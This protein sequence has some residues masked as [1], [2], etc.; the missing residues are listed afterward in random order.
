ME[1]RRRNWVVYSV[2]ACGMSLITPA[3]IWGRFSSVWGAAGVGAAAER[4]LLAKL[5]L[6]APPASPLPPLL[7]IGVS[8]AA[9]HTCFWGT[10]VD[11][12]PEKYRAIASGLVGSALNLGPAL[13]PHWLAKLAG[14]GHGSAIMMCLAGL[15]LMTAL[16]FVMLVASARWHAAGGVCCAGSRT[17]IGGRFQRFE[18]CE[19]EGM[20]A[21]A[22][23]AEGDAGRGR[24]VCS[25]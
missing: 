18:A 2:C 17:R 20:A 11:I 19:L 16:G 23:P 15:T 1:R 12:Y 5:E 25:I 3:T 8:W 4:P 22:H 10:A 9:I 24:G 6:G 7:G 14:A 13:L 21:P